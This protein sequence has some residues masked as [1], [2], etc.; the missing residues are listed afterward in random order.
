MPWGLNRRPRVAPEQSLKLSSLTN[1][2]PPK[3]FGPVP[4]APPRPEVPARRAC[5]QPPREDAPDWQRNR[6]S[7]ERRISDHSKEPRSRPSKLNQRA[8]SP[9]LG[10]PGSIWLTGSNRSTRI[11][12]CPSPTVPGGR[13]SPSLAWQIFH[14]AYFIKGQAPVNQS[15]QL[16]LRPQRMQYFDCTMSFDE[17]INKLDG[18]PKLVAPYCRAADIV[19]LQRTCRVMETDCRFSP[20]NIQKV[21]EQQCNSLFPQPGASKLSSI[22]SL[23]ALNRAQSNCSTQPW[24]VVRFGPDEFDLETVSAEVKQS[25]MTVVNLQAMWPGLAAICEGH[26]KPTSAIPEALQAS[27]SRAE[28]VRAALEQLGCEDAAALGWGGLGKAVKRDTNVASL[29]DCV[30]VR[31]VRKDDPLWTRATW[32]QTRQGLVK[33]ALAMAVTNPAST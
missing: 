32:R 16:Q 20:D 11:S 3:A 8:H 25:L 14:G 13:C 23:A 19:H 33:R 18:F 30:E 24:A 26:S 6:G 4:E 9:A 15:G 7:K 1:A 12:R 5:P 22:R 17:L 27:R 21:A 2:G 29:G 31:L 10:G 28:S